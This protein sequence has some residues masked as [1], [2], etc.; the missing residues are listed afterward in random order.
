MSDRQDIIRELERADWIVFESSR[1]VYTAAHAD[2]TEP[3]KFG[4]RYGWNL[5]IIRRQAAEALGEATGA[6]SARRHRL[7]Q[8][9][10]SAKAR[11]TRNAY[12]VQKDVEIERERV[13][14]AVI[15]RSA[16]LRDI[17]RLMQPG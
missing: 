5:K 17:S 6:P 11:A 12:L 7:T 13:R 14:S 3:I 16:E 15:R 10:E 2:A 4:G 9:Q 1:G 8:S